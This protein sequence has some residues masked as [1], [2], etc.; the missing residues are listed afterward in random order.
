VSGWAAGLRR[1]L[2]AC[3]LLFVAPLAAAGEIVDAA[4][5]EAAL[6]RGAIVWDVR[7]AAA[8]QD[9]H[10][11]GAVNVGELGAVLRDPNREDWLPAGQVQAVLGRGGIDPLQR[12]V[13]AYGRLG[14][15]NAYHALAGLRHFGSRTAKVFHGGLDAWQAAGKLVSKDRTVLAPVAL[16]L[17]PTSGGEVLWTPE[18]LQ[19]VK[20]GRTQIV[21]ARTAKEFSG[22]DVRAIR[23][24]HIPGAV[25]LP[26]ENQWIDPQTG[27]KLAAKQ[28]TTRAGMSLKPADELRKLYAGLDPEREVVVYCQSGVRASVTATVLRELGFKDVKLYEPS[29]LGYAGVLSAPAQDEV[30]VN[31]GALNGRIAT[32]QGR[33]GELEAELSRL[34]TGR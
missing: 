16:T 31:V 23:G 20:A 30:F 25:N 1:G 15:P 33:L 10:I 13:I 19:R 12:E 6:A 32:L 3:A 24:G 8:Y 2:W 9:G 27:A 34:K 11:P 14:D 28:V 22:E 21:D 18:M 5:I 7:D 17:T 26:F 29:W 4:Y